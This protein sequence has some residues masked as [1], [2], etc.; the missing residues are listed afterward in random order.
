MAHRKQYNTGLYYDHDKGPY[1][2]DW[3]GRPGLPQNAARSDTLAGVL[4]EV[5][6]AKAVVGLAAA[7]HGYKASGGSKVAAAAFGAAGVLA[8]L[9]GGAAVA[10]DTVRSGYAT[11]A[12]NS[13]AAMIGGLFKKKEH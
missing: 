5:T 9:L 1:V 2:Y 13:L 7:Y 4:P 6:T 11:R 3:D 10:V 8:P 12:E